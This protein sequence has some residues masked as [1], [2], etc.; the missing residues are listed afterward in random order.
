MKVPCRNFYQI[1]FILWTTS[2]HD[3]IYLIWN[4]FVTL[5]WPTVEKLKVGDRKYIAPYVMSDEN[6]Y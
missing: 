3:Q 6:D 1:Y 4:A 2:Q 5:S